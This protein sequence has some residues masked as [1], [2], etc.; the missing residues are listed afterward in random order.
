MH[1]NRVIKILFKTNISCDHNDNN[2]EQED[3][4]KPFNIELLRAIAKKIAIAYSDTSV[5]DEYIGAYWI[6]VNKDNKYNEK[7]LIS[8]GEWEE[9]NVIK[10]EVV[11]ICNFMQ[12]IKRNTEKMNRGMIIMNN[13]NSKLIRT[14]G[15]RIEKAS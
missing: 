13:N 10:A 2:E 9:R 6:I 8:S 3:E 5:K 1:R 12:A 7:K 14:L 4:Y 15:D 11:S